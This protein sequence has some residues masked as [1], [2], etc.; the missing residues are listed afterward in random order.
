MFIDTHDA[1][2]GLSLMD[3]ALCRDMLCLSLFTFHVAIGRLYKQHFRKCDEYPR[4]FQF[5][6][7]NTPYKPC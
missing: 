7:D 5:Y 6:R 3:K 1:E 2:N 4:R